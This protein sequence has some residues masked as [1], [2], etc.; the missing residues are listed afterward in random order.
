MSHTAYDDYLPCSV[1]GC[2]NAAVYLDASTP[3]GETAEGLYVLSL[4]VSIAPMRPMLMAA[5]SPTL[6][7]EVYGCPLH[8]EILESMGATRPDPLMGTCWYCKETKPIDA[9]GWGQVYNLR[10]GQPFDPERLVCPECEENITR[11]VTRAHERTLA[12]GEIRSHEGGT[13]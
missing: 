13:Q 6:Q 7:V 5:G 8:R 12:E 3:A 2:A 11:P 4:P 9:E 1:L 10:T